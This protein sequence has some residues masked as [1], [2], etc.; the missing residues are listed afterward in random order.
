MPLILIPVPCH[1]GSP[2]LQRPSAVLVYSIQFVM[3]IW[4]GLL[5][6]NGCQRLSCKNY[7][8]AIST[9]IVCRSLPAVLHR[10]EMAR[11]QTKI[12]L[13]A[14][15][16]LTWLVKQTAQTCMQI[17]VHPVLA[18]SCTDQPVWCTRSR[19]CFAPIV[20]LLS[21]SFYHELAHVC[22]CWKDLSR[23]RLC[24]QQVLSLPA[25]KIW[26]AGCR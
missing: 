2:A 5:S 10:H 24:I 21:S 6:I 17:T 16:I 4:S 20:I 23:S 15:G 19:C 8:Q 3:S 26:Q 22:G 12:V 18:C 13:A 14:V 9:S 11:L 25:T 7:F 1:T